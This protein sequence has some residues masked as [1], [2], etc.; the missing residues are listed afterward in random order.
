VAVALLIGTVE[1]GGLAAQKLDAHGQFWSWL[2]HI[3]IGSLGMIIVA[4]FVGTWL[5]ALSI[6]HFGHIEERFKDQAS[7]V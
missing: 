3:D 4:M 5:L 7:G 1:L 2:E 6:W